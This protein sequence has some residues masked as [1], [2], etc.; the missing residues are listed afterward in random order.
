MDAVTTNEQGRLTNEAIRSLLEHLIETT[1]DGARGFDEAAEHVD[2]TTVAALFRKLGAERA[3]MAVEL[4]ELATVYGGPV[5]EAGT[6]KG[7]LHRGWIKLKDALTGKSPHAVIAAAEEGEDYAVEQYD[8]A[9]EQALPP[10]VE[11]VVRRHWTA[12][13][14]SHDKVR[15]LEVATD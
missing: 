2:D 1:E 4:R 3:G 11:A 12:I 14:E 8:E 9:L 6:V 10:N 7:A 13:K 15:A 5:E